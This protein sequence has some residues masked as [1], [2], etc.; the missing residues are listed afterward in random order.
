MEKRIALPPLWE[1][2]PKNIDPVLTV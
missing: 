1:S 2:Q